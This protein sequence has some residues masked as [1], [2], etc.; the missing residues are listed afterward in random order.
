MCSHW[1]VDNPFQIGGPGINVQIDESL[2]K[3]MKGWVGRVPDWQWV[4]GG[5]C[6]E[7][8]R[9]FIVQV[10]DRTRDTLWPLI[11]Q[12]IAPGSHIVSD[13]WRAYEGLDTLP[14]IMFIFTCPTRPYPFL[15]RHTESRYSKDFGQRSRVY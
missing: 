1:L 6:T 5:Y 12:H 11:Q 14:V 2:V 7:Q 10:P 3:K 8:R 4:F 15:L 9:G 13:G